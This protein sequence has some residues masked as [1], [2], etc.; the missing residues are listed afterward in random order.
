MSRRRRDDRPGLSRRELVVAGAA[1]LAG[2]SAAGTEAQAAPRRRTPRRRQTDVVVVGAGL[3]GLTAA[4]DLAARGRS[5]VVLE[6]RDR[7]GGRTLNASLGGGEVVEVGGQWVGPTQD[8]VT[9]L[10]RSLGVSTFKT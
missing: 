5:V 1:G 2:A 8:R 9:A 10:A 7:V 6:A 4:R 3:A